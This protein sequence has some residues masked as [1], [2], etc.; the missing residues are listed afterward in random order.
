MISAPLMGLWC[1]RKKKKGFWAPVKA[2]V[3]QE[4][5]QPK[6]LIQALFKML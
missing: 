6:L 4:K 3:Q 5:S 1:G 2:L